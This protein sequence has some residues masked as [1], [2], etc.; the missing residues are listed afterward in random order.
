M[1]IAAITNTSRTGATLWAT[2]NVQQYTQASDD[3]RLTVVNSGDN[4]AV[5]ATD[6]EA[7]TTDV[8]VDDTLLFT[9]DGT[10]DTGIPGA[11]SAQRPGAILLKPGMSVPLRW[12]VKTFYYAAAAGSETILAV[13]TED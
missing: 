7:I 1:A 13:V 9:L 12:G 3:L 2:D 5:I 4:A 11:S 8:G 10:V 6:P